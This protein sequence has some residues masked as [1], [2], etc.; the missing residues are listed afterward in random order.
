MKGQHITN[1]QKAAIRV[2]QLSGVEDFV[3]HD[4]R[5][6]V[7]SYMASGGVP[8]LVIGK[9]LNHAD[10]SVTVIYDRHG[11]DAEKREALEMWEIKL[12]GIVSSS[13][14]PPTNKPTPSNPG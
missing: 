5:R 9:I 14:Q 10:P 6:T 8:W 2:K 7:A 13:Q 1:V 3:L 11:Y 4:L 12:L